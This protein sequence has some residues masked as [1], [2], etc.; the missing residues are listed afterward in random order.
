MPDDQPRIDAQFIIDLLAQA[1]ETQRAQ[2]AADLAGLF[3]SASRAYTRRDIDR[4]KVTRILKDGQPVTTDQNGVVVDLNNKS[5]FRTLDFRGGGVAIDADAH[6]IAR[7][8]LS[9]DLCYDII[10]DNNAPVNDGTSNVFNTVQ[11]GF[12]YLE[13][14]SVYYGGRVVTIWVCPSNTT[15]AGALLSTGEQVSMATA[16]RPYSGSNPSAT[17]A[18]T[19]SY[20]E[21]DPGTHGNLVLENLAVSNINVHA[22]TLALTLNEVFVYNS[23]SQTG[24]EVGDFVLVPRFTNTQF[25]LNS[26]GGINCSVLRDGWI[27]GGSLG[28]VVTRDI[29]NMRFSNIEGAFFLTGFPFKTWL[30]ITGSY[31]NVLL[32][33]VAPDNPV[34]GASIV[35]MALS[36]TTYNNKRLIVTGCGFGASAT[37]VSYF[38]REDGGSQTPTNV[39]IE[40]NTGLPSANMK[41]AIG[42]F[43]GSV[44]GPNTPD[45]LDYSAVTNPEPAQPNVFY[46]SG[47]VPAGG[48]GPAQS[49]EPYV[50]YGAAAALPN[51][52]QYINVA[53][54]VP[55]QT[56]LAGAFHYDSLGR[57]LYVNKDGSTAW[58]LPLKFRVYTSLGENPQGVTI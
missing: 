23:I 4:S 58:G 16:A 33:G 36:N 2:L 44:F 50:V 19:I 54:N 26:G 45:D 18:A 56:A 35:Y 30:A 12:D 52:R 39:I 5:L 10:I 51:A 6:E 14:G 38:I 21:I 55:G 15:Y 32:D 40:G 53:G 29:A 24:V 42:A 13:S 41:G 8:S 47:V 49:D 37:G 17:A 22:G 3:A 1:D 25:K 48:G 31:S 20:L 34:N 7:V 27:T 9:G 11:A 57:D 28:Y 43:N 46:T